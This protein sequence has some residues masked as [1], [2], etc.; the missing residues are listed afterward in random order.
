MLNVATQFVSLGPEQSQF[1]GLSCCFLLILAAMKPR[2][3]ALLLL[4]FPARADVYVRQPA[5]D[6]VH[7]E[8]ALE[9]FDSVDEISAL[10]RAH[11]KIRQERT[12]R[13]WL[14]FG[15][16]RILSLRV[17]G[18][19]AKY[20]HTG[21]R[22]S[23]ELDR[24]YAPGEIAVIEV[25]YRGRPDGK[26]VLIGKNN[27]GRR[28]F[29]AENWPDHARF[30]FPCIDHPSDKATVEWTL[31]APERYDAVANGR[32]V[33]S[34]SLLDGRRLTRWSESTPIPTYCMVFGIAE[35]TITHAGSARGIPLTYYSY[36]QDSRAA[37][38]RFARSGLMMEHFSD[39]I[40]PYPYEK[41]AQVQS[42]TRIGGM[43]NSNVIFY[44]E[45]GF[46]RADVSEEPVP[47][48]IAHQWFGDSVT[49][50]DWDHLWIS[51][52]FANYF[53]SLFYERVEGSPSLALS[54]AR[55]AET[56]RQ[57]HKIRPAPIV[58][59]ALTDVMKKLNPNTYQ[60]GAWVLHMLR[61]VLGD[62]VFFAGIRRYYSEFAGRNASSEDFQRVM[63]SF[64][65]KSLQRFFRQWL[66]QPG[67]P[68]YRVTWS[69]DERAGEAV[70]RFDQTQAAG[71]FDMPV[72]IAFD[73]GERREL[74]LVR[75]GEKEETVRV[76]LPKRPAALRIDPD[77]W[78]LHTATIREEP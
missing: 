39:L 47:H 45:R 54:M 1:V 59:S 46:Q 27:H 48:E 78:L 28:V 30:W 74:R 5:I 17:G 42:T 7:Y 77:G 21:D 49:A 13:L 12:R 16:L 43:E 52:G 33:E 70:V 64:S 55:A 23:L 24:E 26:G 60:K 34:R 61:R 62:E 18:A 41:L 58:D 53:S 72:E 63:E 73:M 44:S 76:T 75:V 36:P 2:I 15:G 19:E 4:V 38:A 9:V 3:L 6:A 25:R 56:V 67:W 35:F 68:E 65:G 10:T 51:E 57:Y 69:W 14:D 71:L 20:M 50:S 32:L 40:G 31:T 66:Y 22:L 11:V 37:L 29:F 8:I